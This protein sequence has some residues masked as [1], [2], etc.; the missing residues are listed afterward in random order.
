MTYWYIIIIGIMVVGFGNLSN[1][2][3][4]IMK[5]MPDS[6][7]NAKAGFPSLKEIIGKKV[8]IAFDDDTA[9]IYGYKSKGILKEYNNTWLVLEA[10]DKKNGK[11]LFYYRI[12]NVSSINILDKEEV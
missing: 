7:K 3:D 5:N 8:E 11:E 6:T 12:H 2:I 10:S 9:L 4:K 1:K